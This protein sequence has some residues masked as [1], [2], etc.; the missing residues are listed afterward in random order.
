VF[1]QWAG[2]RVDGDACGIGA[3]VTG[4][5]AFRLAA[6]VPIA[7]CVG[8]GVPALHG[9]I[10]EAATQAAVVVAVWDEFTPAAHG[11]SSVVGT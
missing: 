8:L 4:G 5:E 10:V 3:P 2:Q 7:G 1:R 6:D 9:R 11:C